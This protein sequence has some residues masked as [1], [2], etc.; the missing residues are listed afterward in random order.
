MENYLQY[1][2]VDVRGFCHPAS[3]FPF[4]TL[5]GGDHLLPYQQSVPGEAGNIPATGVGH[6]TVK[7]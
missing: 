3:F 5:L 2:R 7:L 6:M 4:L 1:E